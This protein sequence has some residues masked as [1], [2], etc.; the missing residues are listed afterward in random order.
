MKEIFDFKRFGK[1]F[2]Y[3]LR[4]SKNYYWVSLL[5]CAAMPLIC[6]A[7]AQTFSRI[8][9]G[10]WISNSLP[11]QI[12]SVVMAILVALFTYPVKAYGRL[13]DKRAGSSWVMLPASSVEK[14]LS[15]IITSCVVFPLILFGLM[16]GID[17]LMSIVFPGSWP[18]PLVTEIFGLS[19]TVEEMSTGLIQLNFPMALWYTWITNILTF[20]LGSIF[21][22]KA[23]IGKT[24]LVLFLLGQVVSIAWSFILVGS[25]AFADL[26]KGNAD[27]FDDPA[28]TV[29]LLKNFNWFFVVYLWGY[30]IIIVGL[31]W[32]RIKTIKH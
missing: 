4:N 29:R 26:L 27:R 31:L 3:D 28:W 6:F 1:F 15:V 13:T 7:I 24:F 9:F 20:I 5:I 8:F 19:A 23:K 17:A 32:A 30:F 22:K 21:F 25:P 16:T 2:L 12:I 10:S 11:I 18:A 14:T